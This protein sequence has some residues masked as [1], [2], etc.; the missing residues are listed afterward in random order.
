[1]SEKNGTLDIWFQPLGGHV[2]QLTK[3]KQDGSHLTMTVAPPSGNHPATVWELHPS[4]GKLIGT[5]KRGTN[6]IAL[7]GM[8]APALN[9][10]PPASWS[11]PEALFNGKNLDGWTPVPGSGESHWVAKNGVLINQAR[12]GDLMTTR[13]FEDFK[14]HYEVN[15]PK[16]GNSG[17]YLRGRY[18]VQV[19]SEP[20]DQNKPS[21]RIG[22]IYGR[23]AP[24]VVLPRTPGTW[25]SFDVTLV[26]RTV[27]VHQNG[28]LIIDHKL[29]KGITG[30]ALNANEGEPGPFYL[31]G[32]ETGGA[33][34]RDITV[35]VP[36]S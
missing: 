15:C 26:G 8:R 5:Q 21:E 36:R 29:I 16:N 17:V 25:E 9:H 20:V 4:N 28:K 7:T 3:Y 19:E 12:G 18:E 6:T 22:A 31:Q 35:Q 1:I 10:Q 33:K 2:Y 13:K 27:T 23:I 11:K 24:S 30:G 14:L 32:S 34:F